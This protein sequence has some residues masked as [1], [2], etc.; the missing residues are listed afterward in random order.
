MKRVGL[1]A[2][3]DV[4]RQRQTSRWTADRVYSVM[5]AIARAVAADHA[6]ALRAATKAEASPRRSLADVR[7]MYLPRPY[8]DRQSDEVGLPT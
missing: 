8:S 2:V 3:A 6:L 1:P 7:A 4:W 5:R